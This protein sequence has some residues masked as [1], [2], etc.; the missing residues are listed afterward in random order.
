MLGVKYDID[1][2]ETITDDNIAL[3]LSEIKQLISIWSSRALTP[4]GKVVI[5]KSLLMSKITHILRSLSTPSENTFAQLDNLFFTFIWG[6]K[7][8]KFRREIVEANIIKGGLKLHNLKKFDAALKIGWLKRYISTKS[9]WTIT[10]FVN[11]FDGLFRFGID[12]IERLLEMTFNPFWLDVLKSLKNLW[13]DDKI[14]IKDN[15]LL[16]PIW[17][18][19]KLRLQVKRE[20]I[21]KGIYTIN[22]LL[23]LDGGLLTLEKFEQKYHLRSNL[24]EFGVVCQKI[25]KFLQFR[26]R[27]PYSIENP[28]DCLLNVVLRKDTKGVST[29]YSLLLNKNTSIIENACAKWNDK[30]GDSTSF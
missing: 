15:I 25:N 28:T 22:D 19:D 1:K 11:E 7:P 30:I 24:L 10:Q 21:L 8:P 2:M 6:N 13:T 5:I 20:W 9:K 27:P 3:K 17:Y 23:D 14:I 18:N 4:Y 16:T 26:E 12:Y 29:I